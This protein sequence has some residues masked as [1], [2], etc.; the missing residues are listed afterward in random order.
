ATCRRVCANLNE[1]TGGFPCQTISTRTSPFT[2]SSKRRKGFPSETRVKRGFRVV[3]GDKEL[4][5]KLGRNDLGP[6]GSGRKFKNCCLRRRTLRCFPPGPL[7]SENRRAHASRRRPSNFLVLAGALSRTRVNSA[8]SD[9]HLSESCRA[10]P[11]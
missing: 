3:H 6:C 2:P 8:S 11:G 5:E 10:R 4:Q 9:V 1:S 7:L